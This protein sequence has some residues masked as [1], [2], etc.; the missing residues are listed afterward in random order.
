MTIFTISSI[1][2]WSCFTVTWFC[3][4]LKVKTVFPCQNIKKSLHLIIVSREQFWIWIVKSGKNYA[5][6]IFCSIAYEKQHRLKR[7]SGFVRRKIFGVCMKC[8]TWYKLNNTS[9]F[10]N[11][12]PHT[13]WIYG[14]HGLCKK[15]Y[16]SLNTKNT[17]LSR[18]VFLSFEWK[19][20]SLKQDENR[21]ITKL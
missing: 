5:N 19:S 14:H 17:L 8:S 6:F 15:S 10:S 9:P 21:N 7:E 12:M 16:K 2:L 1:F 3:A 13:L 4:V 20:F 11:I 18:F